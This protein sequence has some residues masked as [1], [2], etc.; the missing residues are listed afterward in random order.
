MVMRTALIL[1][2]LTSPAL[3]SAEDDLVAC[4]VG[5][6]AAVLRDNGSSKEEALEIAYGGCG[7]EEA[8]AEQTAT[9]A[10]VSDYVNLMV[11]RMAAE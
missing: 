4:M 11:E 7:L 8:S 10:K 5:K 6:A 9:Y 3:A 1:A 2:L